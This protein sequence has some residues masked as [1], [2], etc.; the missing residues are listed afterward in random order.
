[1]EYNF[2]STNR[3][4]HSQT[5]TQ[6]HTHI[7]TWPHTQA[8]HAHVQLPYLPI[9]N[10]GIIIFTRKVSKFECKFLSRGDS[11]PSQRRNGQK[12]YRAFQEKGNF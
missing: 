11:F 12:K 7:H 8:M 9:P 3:L 4:A 5:D 6:T 2:D 10:N 1:M